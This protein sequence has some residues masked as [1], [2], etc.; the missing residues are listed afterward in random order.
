[1]KILSPKTYF[2]MVD[3]ANVL[4]AK[5]AAGVDPPIALTECLLGD[6]DY[7]YPDQ[8]ES[9][10]EC[11]DGKPKLAIS[12]S[13][14]SYHVPLDTS[15]S[16]PVKKR[17]KGSPGSRP[18][19]TSPNACA[20]R[21][22]KKDVDNDESPK[23]FRM[24]QNTLQFLQRLSI[25]NRWRATTQISAIRGEGESH[26][27]HFPSC[28]FGNREKKYVVERDCIERDQDESSSSSLPSLEPPKN[29]F[30]EHND[31]FGAVKKNRGLPMDAN[32]APIQISSMPTNDVFKKKELGCHQVFSSP[33]KGSGNKSLEASPYKCLQSLVSKQ[34]QHSKP[35][36][37]ITHFPRVV[38]IPHVL[39][40][41]GYVPLVHPGGATANLRTPEAL[42]TGTAVSVP[43]ADSNGKTEVDNQKGHGQTTDLAS[44]PE[45]IV[46][47]P[48]EETMTSPGG[49]Q[50]DN[51][52]WKSLTD[53]SD[54]PRLHIA[55]QTG[56]SPGPYTDEPIEG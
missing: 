46:I 13:Q 24:G 28:S 34:P 55:D 36:T 32:D 39:T 53:E 42:A 7:H 52:D 18:E 45:P 50:D 10:E 8:P 4:T 16:C 14:M 43:D 33:V 31:L 27:G 48:S 49:S 6:D 35:S 20:Q 12:E 30:S 11:L 9:E 2:Y 44:L 40:P 1:M 47:E 38:M 3:M 51:E 23:K 21:L 29:P 22:G 26:S 5:V 17:R 37:T 56:P 19:V 54:S 15:G 41:G 25:G